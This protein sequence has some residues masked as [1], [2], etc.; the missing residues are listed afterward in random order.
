MTKVTNAR[1]LATGGASLSPLPT[2][3]PARALLALSAT[4]ATMARQRPVD[5]PVS[6][7]M[8]RQ[9]SPAALN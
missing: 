4:K 1:L 9:P 3:Y 5:R 6:L 8:E 7:A 2:P